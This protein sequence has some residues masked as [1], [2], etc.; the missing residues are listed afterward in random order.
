MDCRHDVSVH[1]GPLWIARELNSSISALGQRII[2]R[3]PLAR[4]GYSGASSP[5][6]LWLAISQHCGSDTPRYTGVAC[7][8]LI[9][10][11]VQALL[12]AV[13][14]DGDGLPSLSG[15][16]SRRDVTNLK[17]RRLRAIGAAA[18][19]EFVQAMES[20]C[21]RVS[22]M[23]RLLSCSSVETSSSSFHSMFA[24]RSARMHCATQRSSC[25]SWRAWC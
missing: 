16:G 12:L 1:G 25:R 15:F 5:E 19:V 13:D 7:T 8:G 2:G 3:A 17:D 22:R 18:S 11:S 6:L 23:Q 21:P 24:R 9:H 20:V 4:G 14:E 10:P